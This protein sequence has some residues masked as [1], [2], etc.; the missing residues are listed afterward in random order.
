VAA[1]EGL[2][3]HTG[4]MPASTDDGTDN[5]LPQISQAPKA[6]ARVALTS[7]VLEAFRTAVST[8][9]AVSGL[10]LARVAKRWV[11]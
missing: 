9:F 6:V 7:L 3:A 4:P 2:Q 5:L 11:S 8:S 10:S 1:P